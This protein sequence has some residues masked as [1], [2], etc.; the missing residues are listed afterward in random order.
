MLNISHLH[1]L[2][3]FYSIKYFSL[4]VFHHLRHVEASVQREL[5]TENKHEEFRVSSEQRSVADI[6]FLVQLFVFDM[7]CDTESTSCVSIRDRM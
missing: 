4:K 2:D 1:L 5:I 6:L 7:R 3:T